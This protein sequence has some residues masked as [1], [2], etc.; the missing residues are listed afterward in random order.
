MILL[1]SFNLRT[2]MTSVGPVMDLIQTEYGMSAGMAGLITTLPL[3]M[4]GAASPFV[5]A[6]NRRLGYSRT[7]CI[8][9]ASII[10]G[11]LLRN[12]MGLTGLFAGTALIGIGI[13]IGNVLLP[14]YVRS[15]SPEKAGVLTGLYTAG[16]C[17]FS[18]VGAGLCV[19]LSDGMG[20]GWRG[21]L[22]V[23][24]SVAVLAL[25]VWVPGAM[26]GG[27]AP[28]GR[29]R[30]SVSVWRCGTAWWVTLFMGTQSLVFYTLVT[31]L[32]TMVMAKGF[33]ASF[34]GNMALIYQVVAIPT[35]L[36]I[37]VACSKVRDQ[38]GII[39]LI[40]AWYISGFGIFLA[41][42]SSAA[43]ISASALMA[44]AMGG[45][46]YKLKYGHRG[47]NQPV[48]DC[49]SG[50]CYITSQNHGY[51][52]DS[53]SMTGIARLSYVNANDGSCEGLDYP[54]QNCFTVQF[55]PEACS[56]PRDTGF[57]FD[58]FIQMMGGV[59]HAQG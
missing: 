28:A 52:V 17:A 34:A 13:G 2:P 50:R 44:L 46:T 45:K 15:R 36:L 29:A 19:P 7:M 31:W 33:D 16:M 14:G 42:D 27:D 43:I 20:L 30:G 18:A 37:P 23:W 12:L 32:P 5:P 26:K 24:V 56:G 48:K 35:S 39:L 1:V 59:R 21:A 55:H 40:C 57:L 58:R 10:A 6:V 8:A 11:E 49:T 38:R 22:T 25:I 53:D 9:I 41:S 54:E 47:G 51:A 3:I 4:F